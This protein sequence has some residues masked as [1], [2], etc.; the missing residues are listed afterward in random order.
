MSRRKNTRMFPRAERRADTAA[1]VAAEAALTPEQRDR[2]EI[3]G[4]GIDPNA[5]APVL[6]EAWL[7]LLDDPGSIMP[8]A[9]ERAVANALRRHLTRL[10]GR[11]IDRDAA[12][13]IV[14]HDPRDEAGWD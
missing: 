2:R 5:G 1:R 9:A 4:A 7:G 10:E 14:D 12:E 11:R 3:Q 13:A 6:A 8:P